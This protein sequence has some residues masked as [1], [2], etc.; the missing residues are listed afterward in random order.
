[1][2]NG[3]GQQPERPS[4]EQIEEMVKAS[5]VNSKPSIRLLAQALHD[6]GSIADA[7]QRIATAC[8]EEV[9][10]MTRKP[11]LMDQG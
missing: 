4:L 8:E 10:E 1:M 7:L 3:N 11:S 2:P 6:L 5:I 9:V